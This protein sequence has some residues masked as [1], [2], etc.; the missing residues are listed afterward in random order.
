MNIIIQC[1]SKKRGGFFM[2]TDGREIFFVADPTLA[3]KDDGRNYAR[4]DDP[5][6]DGLTWREAVLRYNAAPDNTM[7]LARA[8]EIYDKVV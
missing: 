6:E 1:A 4:P 5:A 3:P 2:A 7:D 8:F